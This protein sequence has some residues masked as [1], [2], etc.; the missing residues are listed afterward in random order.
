MD[1]SM[2]TA[3]REELQELLVSTVGTIPVYYQPPENVKM[4][5]P[6]FIISLD[7][8]DIIYADG[9]PYYSR[10]RFILTYIT[11]SVNDEIIST[12][13]NMKRYISFDRVYTADNL[14][15]YVFNVHLV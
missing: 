6:C 7:D 4:T 3:R 9:H 15:H 13:L 8:T 2:I 10:A 12:L 5:Y 11:R 14:R 1:L